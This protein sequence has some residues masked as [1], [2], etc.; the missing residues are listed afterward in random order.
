MPRLRR[1][2]RTRVQAAFALGGLLVSVFLGAVSW[3]LADTYLT[4]QRELGATRSALVGADLLDRR[5]A[6]AQPVRPADVRDISTLGSDAFYLPPSPGQPVAATP[7]VPVRA[8]PPDLLELAASGTAAQQR[9]RL[10]GQ[11]VLAVALPVRGGTYV[12]LFRLTALDRTLRT[13]SGVLAV[14]ALLGTLLA[15]ALGRWAADRSLRPLRRLITSAA[16]VAGG[17]L[18]RRLDAGGDPDL[19][20]LTE[21][22]NTTTTALR[23]RIA[24]DA[25]FAGDVSHELRSPVTTMVNAAE[26]LRN[27]RDELSPRGREALDLLSDEVARFRSLVEDLLEVSREDQLPDL[28]PLRLGPLVRRVADRCAGREVTAV[29]PAAETALVDA[30][31]R[32]LERVVGNLVDNAERHGRGVRSVRVRCVPGALQVVVQDRGPG[33]PEADR[34]RVFERFYRGQESR[35]GTQGSGLGLALARQ[36]AVAQGGR[37][38]VEAGVPQGA[39]FVL[40]LPLAEDAP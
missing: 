10:D 18:D 20:P 8:L 36:H 39:V 13:L 3:T 25:R 14:T 26:V 22:F 12:E 27:R 30:D 24:R 5:L 9:L 37:L 11:P 7:R 32:R 19:Q 6:R 21:A 17:R 34:E 40:E 29:D 1:G 4:D 31:P 33:V 23:E 2:V 15:A 16:E 28:V 35:A 38:W